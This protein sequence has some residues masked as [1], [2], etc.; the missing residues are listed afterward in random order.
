MSHKTKKSFHR[1]SKGTVA[2]FFGL[3]VIPMLAITGGAID[4]STAVST[5][6]KLQKALDA[7]TVAVCGGGTGQQSTEEI[8]RA[9]LGAELANSGM[10]V[11]PAP[12]ASETP[13]E[14]K[15][16]E[17]ELTGA[18][19]VAADGSVR[20][21]LS[22][23]IPT[24][25]LSLIG[26]NDIEIAVESDVVCGAKRLE[27]SLVLDVTG[28]MD[29]SVNGKKKIDS[30]KEASLDV[31]DIFE[32]NLDAGVTR[33]SLVPFSEGV[34]V[35]SYANAVRGTIQSGTSTSVGKSELKFRDKYY[36]WKYYDATS[37]VSERLGSDK[38]T[39]AAPSCSGSS[40]S[41]P[42]GHV[43][44]SNGNCKPNHQLQPLTTDKAALRQQ[45]NSY[46]PNGGTAGHIGAAWGWYTLSD[47]WSG[48]F[49]GTAAPEAPNPEELI[50]ATIIMTDGEF[51]EEYY[52][53]VD[54]DNTYS[55]S[56][57][58]S[59]NSQFAK[60]CEAMKDPNGDGVYDEDDSVVVYAIGFGLS[61]SSNTAQRLKDCA[62]DDTKWFFPYNGEELRAAFQSIGKQLSGGQVGKA[63]V[64]N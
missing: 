39:D 11:L 14:P 22:T 1:D 44:T 8:V 4:M 56:N 5:Q 48:V 61:S 3:M 45:I 32:R 25:I 7:A 50:K 19:M 12:V 15:P 17:L 10:T 9:Y 52:N 16:N 59:S 38:Y 6:S 51:N 60:I 31:I 34:N 63:V 35:G 47:K 30:M 46:S 26:I 53:G 2:P 24:K 58:G 41:A 21:S 13:A 49:T 27:L 36:N 37:C 23:R 40:C 20:P 54:D 18:E 28:S 33:I 55:S 29:S 42:V 62:T 64:R 57:N 43:Y